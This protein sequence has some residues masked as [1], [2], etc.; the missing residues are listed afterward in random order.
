MVWMGGLAGSTKAAN[1]PQLKLR[2]EEFEVR[3]K[4]WWKV[5]YATHKYHTY[6]IGV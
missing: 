4:T 6:H 3:R 1:A 5:L 2:L